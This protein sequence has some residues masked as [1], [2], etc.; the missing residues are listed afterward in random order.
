MMDNIRPTT[1]EGI[2]SLASQL[3]RASKG[4]I[5]HCQ[6]LEIAAKRAGYNTYAHALYVLQPKAN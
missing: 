3:K 4:T 5:K 2:K 6:A 1:I